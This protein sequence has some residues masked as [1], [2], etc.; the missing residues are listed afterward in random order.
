[1]QVY[2]IGI[3]KILQNTYM[4][5]IIYNSI[6]PKWDRKDPEHCLNTF[7]NYILGM[8]EFSRDVDYCHILTCRELY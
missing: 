1:M 7:P 5:N 8:Y 4:V 6:I 2:A 3:I